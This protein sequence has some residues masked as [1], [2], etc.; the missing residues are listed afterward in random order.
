MYDSAYYHY[1][2][3]Y[4]YFS[5]TSKQ[6][7]TAQMLY[8]MSL[9]RGRY[10]DYAGSELLII[11]SI[12]IYRD[13][14]DY[15][16]L[17][18]SYNHLAILQKDIKEYDRAIKYH[19]IAMSYLEKIPDN[20]K[21]LYASLN[22]IGIIY[23]DQGNYIEALKKFNFILEDSNL[24]KE[25]SDYYARALDNLAYCKLLIRDTI[26]IRKDL[27]EALDTRE[28]IGNRG[29]VIVS[30]IHL[31]KFYSY[32]EDT[33]IAFKNALEAN[34]IA[35][36]IKNSSN[37]L[38]TL[39]MLS[40]LD[41]KNA[42]I[43]L[44]KYISYN[45]SLL[46][47]ER[48]VQ[49]KFARIEFE[50]DK[51]IERTQE[52]SEQKIRIFIIALG[53][54]IIISL[55][56]YAFIQRARNKNL[57]L[58]QEKQDAQSQLTLLAIESQKNL[59]KQKIQEQNRISEEIHDNII[60]RL[61]GVRFGFGFL[62]IEKNKDEQS[63]KEMLLEELQ[64]VEIELRDISHQLNHNFINYSMDFLSLIE[65]KIKDKSIQGNFEYQ[66]HVDDDIDW[67][68]IKGIIKVNCLRI[69]Q[70]SLQNIVK[71]AHATKVT[72]ILS[73]KRE[74]IKVSIEDNGV[75][76]D[77][78]KV[79]KGIGLKNIKSRLKKLNGEIRIDTQPGKGTRISFYLLQINN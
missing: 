61:F 2:K 35:K 29:G 70:E 30:K 3:A 72:I 18:A 40:I 62:N 28:K 77:I 8:N 31:S 25:N 20:K 49:N 17:Y 50:T 51:Y 5:K 65:E 66:F 69:I 6:Q 60:G 15:S 9:I 21:Y 48:K 34:K 39:S 12:R 46:Q 43:Y 44:K 79:T 32:K 13:L 26:G 33:A 42:S 7:Y 59:E 71:Y 4:Q 47:E 53:L 75:G 41:K 19:N 10:R 14:K 74:G 52:L 38:Q 58:E 63:R 67:N 68:A 24:R 37:Y 1:N 55:T 27:I 11:K 56:Y 57:V 16:S 76:F 45:D 22:N 36:Q 64:K 23:R 54:V 78:S 73:K